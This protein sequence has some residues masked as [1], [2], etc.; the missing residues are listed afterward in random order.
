[1]GRQHPAWRS[2]LHVIRD[3]L[4]FAT[5]A[6]EVRNPAFAVLDGLQFARPSVQL[7]ALFNVAVAMAQALDLDPHEMV[8]RA[9]R[10]LPDVEGPY[11]EQLSTVRDYAKGELRR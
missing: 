6:A 9:K 8:V 3:S 1:M 11:T 7:D 5:N 10:M 2:P 4:S